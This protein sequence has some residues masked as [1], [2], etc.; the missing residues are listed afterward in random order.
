M[1]VAALRSAGRNG[2][3]SWRRGRTAW[4]PLN[5]ALVILV[6]GVSSGAHAA[7]QKHLDK[8]K[9]TGNCQN[10]DLSGA[11]LDG[12]D[13]SGAILRGVDLHEA[14]LEDAILDDADLTDADLS[15]ANLNGVHLNRATLRG[16]EL[17]EADLR[18]AKL[19]DADLSRADLSFAN[20]RES[21]LNNAVLISANLFS[22]DLRDAVAEN[23][24][25]R[26]AHFS[27]ADLRGT[28]FKNANLEGASFWKAE[29]S[30]A[31]LLAAQLSYADLGDAS[32][33]GEEQLAEACGDVFSARLPG[34][35]VK[36]K[37]WCPPGS[38][39]VTTIEDVDEL[40]NLTGIIAA[41]EN[42]ENESIRVF[43]FSTVARRD[44]TT[45]ERALSGAGFAVKFRAVPDETV[46][47]RFVSGYRGAEQIAFKAKEGI[48]HPEAIGDAAS[49]V[50]NILAANSILGR[51]LPLF[52]ASLLTGAVK[53][54]R[55][56][57][58]I[59]VFFE[60]PS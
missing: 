29:L 5:L 45:I 40:A 46:M 13:L 22:A 36:P 56:I 4:L 27:Q 23:V 9:A 31:N 8:L 51:R 34:Y 30:G 43:V 50:Q 32:G 24:N 11:N 26:D 60:N 53:A 21:E 16:A 1:S 59:V 57:K 12:A 47:R 39:Q 41:N 7:D 37:D 58:R 15:E 3:R 2:L 48:L 52:E 28:N 25:A 6:F 38:T 42:I 35:V 33:L 49:R 20:M 10:C 44:G 17:R 54:E 19:I 14:D 55:V 18:G